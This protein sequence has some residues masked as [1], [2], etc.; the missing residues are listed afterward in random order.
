MCGQIG[1]I[2][3]KD[4]Y[5]TKVEQQNIIEGYIQSAEVSKFF[6]FRVLH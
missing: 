4:K 1:S 6:L 3:F 2:S 5:D